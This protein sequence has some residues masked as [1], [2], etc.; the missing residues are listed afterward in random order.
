ME[1]IESLKIDTYKHGLL[2]L[3]QEAKA[4]QCIKSFLAFCGLSYSVGIVFHK[5]KV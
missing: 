3:D 5:E 1:Q 2:I 4:I